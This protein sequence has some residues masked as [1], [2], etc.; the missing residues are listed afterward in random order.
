MSQSA[1]SGVSSTPASRRRGTGGISCIASQALY[2]TILQV[3]AFLASESVV[4]SSCPFPVA[5]LFS[6]PIRTHWVS[7]IWGCPCLLPGAPTLCLPSPMVWPQLPLVEAAQ[8][9]CVPTAAWNPACCSGPSFFWFMGAQ[10]VPQDLVLLWVGLA[11]PQ[12][13]LCGWML[14]DRRALSIA[15]QLCYLESGLCVGPWPP[16]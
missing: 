6:C 9:S 14:R 5:C 10:V 15:G 16:P 4:L 11:M 2:V 13:P 8:V 1:F 7:I 12:C 3:S